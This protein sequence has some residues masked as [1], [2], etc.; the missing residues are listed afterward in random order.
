MIII[1]KNFTKLKAV[2]QSLASC[3]T[4]KIRISTFAYVIRTWNTGNILDL[5]AEYTCHF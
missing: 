1:W 2:I 5:Y 3:C 4:Y